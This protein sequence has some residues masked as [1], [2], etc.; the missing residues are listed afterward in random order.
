[1]INELELYIISGIATK[2]S[3]HSFYY[4]K[5][6]CKRGTFA[7]ILGRGAS[8]EMILGEAR[9]IMTHELGIDSS[10]SLQVSYKPIAPETIR[11]VY[12]SWIN[13]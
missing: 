12:E 13:K 3:V 7:M 10:Y 1:M 5:D 8:E 9:K 11:D 2:T 4:Q 6:I